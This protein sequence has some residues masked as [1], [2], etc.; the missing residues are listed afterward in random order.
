ME[1]DI[2]LFEDISLQVQN[3]YN[4]WW[5]AWTIYEDYAKDIIIRYLELNK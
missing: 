1:I 3:E 4:M 5:L 2:K